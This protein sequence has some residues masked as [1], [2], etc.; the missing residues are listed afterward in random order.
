MYRISKKIHLS[1][2]II[3]KQNKSFHSLI[4]ISGEVKESLNL[5]KPI[6]A[7]ESTILTHGM[8]YP[9]NV[10]TAI[11]VENIVRSQV[12]KIN[13]FILQSLNG[14]FES[15]SICIS[16]LCRNYT[17]RLIESIHTLM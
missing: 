5:K 15:I 4:D 9:H 6:V 12:K 16:I 10:H 2:E 1:A 3:R 14:I 8:P 13:A 11:E 7:L 17:F